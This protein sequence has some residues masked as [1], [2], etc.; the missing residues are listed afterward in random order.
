MLN[1]AKLATM[2]PMRLRAE[3]AEQVQPHTVDENPNGLNDKQGVVL[4]SYR[5]PLNMVPMVPTKLSD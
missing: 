3:Q 1:L 2:R 4:N 5:K